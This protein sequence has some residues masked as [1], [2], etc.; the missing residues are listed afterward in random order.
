MGQTAE[1]LATE[2]EIGREEQD[3][4][5]VMSQQRVESAT[6]KGY[7]A[8][9]ILPVDAKDDRGHINTV[10]TDE[11]PRSG[12]TVEALAKLPLV[13]SQDGSVTAGNSSGITDGAAALVLMS[14]EKAQATNKTPLGY[15]IDYETIGVDPTRMGIGPVPATRNLLGRH[16]LRL[17]DIPLIELNEADRKSHV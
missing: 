15:V 10:T 5:A 8:K 16:G 9:E 3:R 12:V 17:D 13:F 1:V 7:F 6:Q 11:H 4:Y 14:E 2:Y